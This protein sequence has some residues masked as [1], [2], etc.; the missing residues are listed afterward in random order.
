MGPRGLYETWVVE[1]PDGKIPYFY[2]G[3]FTQDEKDNIE[4]AMT[5]LEQSCKVKFILSSSS[6]RDYK[7]KIV[8]TDEENIGGRS[9]LGYTE[10]AFYQFKTNNYGVILHEL[11]HCLGLSHEHQRDDRDD[12]VTVYED[13]IIREYVNQFD[14][15]ENFFITYGDYDYDSIMHYPA[16]AFSRCCQVYSDICF[17]ENNN[18]YW[19][20]V[21]DSW[22][23][24]DDQLYKVNE[25]TC[26]PEHCSEQYDEGKLITIETDGGEAIGQRD[27]LSSGDEFSLETM[28]GAYN[29]NWDFEND[30]DLRPCITDTCYECYDTPCDA[31]MPCGTEE[32]CC[33]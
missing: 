20:T 28:Y 27:H 4:A 6:P 29:P 2:E 3:T 15:I 23:Y 16:Y 1:W 19:C 14:I 11:C 12:N 31:G 24:L 13:N 18:P 21:C 8:R 32:N 9:T 10:E 25:G 22:D 26:D 7:Y 17:D 33:N 5:T 30:C